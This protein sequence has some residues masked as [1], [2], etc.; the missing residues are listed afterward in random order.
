M[1][2]LKWIIVDDLRST[3]ISRTGLN[4]QERETKFYYMDSVGDLFW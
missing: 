2:F 3:D 1:P 4:R